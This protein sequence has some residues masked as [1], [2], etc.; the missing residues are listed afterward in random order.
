M[1]ALKHFY[2]IANMR[3]FTGVTL[4]FCWIMNL[5]LPS[6]VLAQSSPL[7]GDVFITEVQT[8][9]DNAGQEFIELYNNTDNDIDF[10][11]TTNHGQDV[12]KIQFFSSTKVVA[13]GFNWD[14][15]TS[16][17]TT[18]SLAR[19]DG[20]PS[21]IAANSYYIIST[22]PNGQAYA[23]GGVDPDLTYSSGHMSD[24][25]GGIQ[26]VDVT[27]TSS[28]QTFNVHDHVGWYQPTNTTP[29]PEGFSITPPAN[30]SLQRVTDNDGNY[31]DSEG[32]LLTMSTSPNISPKD[33]WTPPAEPDPSPNPDPSPPADPPTDNPDPVPTTDG[34]DNSNLLPIQIDELLPNPAAPATDTNDE[35][36][37]LYN[38][39]NQ[40]VDLN[41]YTVQTGLTY[42][43]SYT[44]QDKTIPANGYLVLTSGGTNLALSNAGGQARLLDN[45]GLTISTTTAYGEAP[46]GEAWALINDTWQWTTTPTPLAANILTLPAAT[47]DKKT[48]STKKTTTK[49]SSKTTT[50]KP[51]ATKTSKTAGTVA[52]DSTGTDDPAQV[53]SLH[54]AVLAGVA[55]IAVGYGAYEYRTDMANRLRR[56]RS[57]RAARRTARTSAQG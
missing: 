51:K 30:G 24:T 46:E 13:S 35:F 2:K 8:A 22:A 57:H 39:N 56:F 18:I 25:G 19:S 54:P 48:A 33:S 50:S 27:S 55:A 15:K 16:G 45:N 42:S 34:N 11:D 44:I 4:A 23:P 21:I 36:V 3:R 1:H 32:N 53:A 52:G 29:L 43:Y 38:P 37:E 5:C 14:P 28:S 17:L 47:P 20:L 31:T 9:G 12:W 6:F 10:G 41:G 7:P 40:D 49:T 26:L